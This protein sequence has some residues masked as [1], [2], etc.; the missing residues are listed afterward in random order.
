MIECKQLA[1]RASSILGYREMSL[2]RNTYRKGTQI[3]QAS[4]EDRGPAL[5]DRRSV[6]DST[7][8]LN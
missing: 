4:N 7:G 5:L 1:E 6:Q 2:S 8:G 3:A